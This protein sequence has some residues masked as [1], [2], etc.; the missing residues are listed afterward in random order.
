M[1]VWFDASDA[2]AAWLVAAHASPILLHSGAT[3]AQAPALAPASPHLCSRTMRTLDGSTTVI[4]GSGSLLSSLSNQA[5]GWRWCSRSGGQQQ[6]SRAAAGSEV[7]AVLHA[8]AA[9]AHGERRHSCRAAAAKRFTAAS[10]TA[11]KQ[12]GQNTCIA[13]SHTS[14]L[15]TLRGLPSDTP[16]T[17]TVHS[18]ATCVRVSAPAFVGVRAQQQRGSGVAGSVA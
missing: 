4:Q 2:S 3:A 6:G 11:S 1:S 15:S 12:H 18:C 14:V 10:A 17:R 16:D 9:T 13:L 7:S 5:S 8:A